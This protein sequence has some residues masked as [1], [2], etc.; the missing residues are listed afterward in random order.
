MT[1]NRNALVRRLMDDGLTRKQAEAV[2]RSTFAAISEA[3]ARGD[4]V[5]IRGFGRFSTKFRPFHWRQIPRDREIVRVPDRTLVTFT[6]GVDLRRAADA[7]PD[8]GY[9]DAMIARRRRNSKQ[10][11]SQPEHN[12][13]HHETQFD[14][15]IAYREMAL[16]E[17]ALS[18]FHA[19]LALV[20]EREQGTRYVRCCYMIAIC[21]RDLG[22]FE[23]AAEW[24]GAGLAAPKRPVA[25]RLEIQ[26]QLGVL[27]G[28]EGRIDEAIWHLKQ[29]CNLDPVFRDA[30][31]HVRSLQALR[32]ARSVHG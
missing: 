15:G 8:D 28:M 11:L 14:L 4:D 21:H 26:Y 25:E 27:L 13:R 31:E 6:A 16:Y 1:S 7:S 19:A 2:Y 9:F 22:E 30:A 12:P 10:L 3:L 24:F 5:T 32:L 29:V 18:R 17:D 23:L 20:E